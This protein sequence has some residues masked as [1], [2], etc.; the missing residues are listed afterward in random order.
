MRT[1]MFAC[2][3]LALAHEDVLLELLKH[4]ASP[5][6][7]DH[8]DCH[9]ALRVAVDLC[10]NG[11]ADR[12]LCLI[13]GYQVAV[14]RLLYQAH[15][16]DLERQADLLQKLTYRVATSDRPQLAMASDVQADLAKCRTIVDRVEEDFV[17]GIKRHVIQAAVP[18]SDDWHAISRDPHL[19][20]EHL[21]FVRSEEF[22]RRAAIAA[23]DNARTRLQLVGPEPDLED[24]IAKVQTAFA[25]AIR[26]YAGFIENVVSNGIDVSIDRH[27]NTIWD[28]AILHSIGPFALNDGLQAIL[29]SNET[30]FSRYAAE[31]GL[32]ERVWNL[33]KF[34][35]WL[36]RCQSSA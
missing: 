3:A 28:Y 6:D 16:P 8:A 15:P 9:A 13:N 21:Q 7:P 12:G 11:N 35:D 19:R 32:G 36:N 25:V 22:G 31:C 17:S 34:M 30:R 10:W 23:I 2:G 29:V 33:N 24:C 20:S 14:C 4:V 18:G 26:S 27:R 1:K 5:N